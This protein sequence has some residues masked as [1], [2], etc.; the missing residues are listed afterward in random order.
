[1]KKAIFTLTLLLGFFFSNA[2]TNSYGPD[3][4]C[5]VVI[6]TVQNGFCFQAIPS[7]TAPFTYLWSD[8]TTTNTACSN[9]V[10]GQLCVTVVD[11]AGCVAVACVGGT[12]PPTCTAYVYED[13]ILGA[14]SLTL[15]AGSDGPGP[16]T[17]L[18]STGETT[19][20][21][22]PSVTG[23]YCVTVTDDDGCSDDACYYVDLNTNPNTC[24]AYITE[25]ST[26]A[27]LCLTVVASGTAPFTYS[28]LNGTSTDPTFCVGNGGPV[29]PDTIC[30]IVTDASGC[31]TT[32]CYD[33]SDICSVYI[34]P[35]AS[36]I[37]A[38]ASGDPNNQY[39]YVWSTGETTS[40][41]PLTTS[42]TYC[43]TI[44]NSFGCEATSCY[45]FTLNDFIEGYVTLDSTAL[46]GGN[47]GVNTFLVYLIE[48]DQSAGTLT[49]IDSMLVTSTPNNWG[50]FYSFTGLASGD[51]LVKAAIQPGSDQYDHYLPTYY[52]D[53]LYW[54]QATSI[55][56]PSTQNS[57]NII[58]MIYGTNPGGPGFIGG[59]IIDGAN[60]TSNQVET[61][62][63]GDPLENISVLL[64]TEN[65]EPITHTVTDVNGEFEFP[66]VAYGTYKLVVEVLG[67]AQGIKFVTIGPDNPTVDDIYFEVNSEFVTKVE[68]VLNGETLKV[69]PNPAGETLN[70]QVDIKASTQL[71]VS[72][73]SLLGKQIISETLQFNEGTQTMTIQ[74]N[75]LPSGVYF[76]NLSDGESILSRKIMKK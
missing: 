14:P 17:Y 75:Q 29:I 16:L 46:G 49:A 56:V 15:V 53:V 67:K 45:T 50:A 1:M 31:T 44:T 58:N 68:D 25:D 72:V 71:N 37:T 22:V 24:S 36:G 8:S 42:G 62:G 40:S 43:V 74:V 33:L 70:V 65:D 9:I 66:S 76:L 27:G 60:F 38:V 51:Y 73:T 63:D 59:L 2:N 26:F 55:T 10:F 47:N 4:T 52:G 34:V 48:H 35:T 5:S 32:V 30:V 6:D 3:S 12:P 21:I 69:F 20:H 41:I 64:L 7:G 11:A 57:W 19:Q 13:S 23:T 54:D 18:W 39:T 61:R 28:W